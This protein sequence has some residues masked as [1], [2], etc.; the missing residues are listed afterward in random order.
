MPS[1]AP[2]PPG[3]L[4]CAISVTDLVVGRSVTIWWF[5]LAEGVRTA[6]L[7]RVVQVRGRS[8]RMPGKV[9]GLAA[10]VGIAI[11]VGIG[12][13]LWARKSQEWFGRRRSAV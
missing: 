1:A 13:L 4:R 3:S 6:T 10:I 9:D 2:C 8:E 12:W 11:E 7:P 5:C